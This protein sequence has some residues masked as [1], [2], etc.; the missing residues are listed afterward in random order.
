VS[1]YIAQ[2]EA[3][4]LKEARKKIGCCDIAAKGCSLC[5]NTWEQ[6]GKIWIAGGNTPMRFVARSGKDKTG[7]VVMNARVDCLVKAANDGSAVATAQG[8]VAD[9]W[10]Y[11]GT[12]HGM[13][14]KLC[15]RQ[16]YPRLCPNTAVTQ[17]QSG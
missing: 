14:R 10:V 4:F 16:G 15:I 9:L 11:K 8:V 3:Q 2:A 1:V 12:S 7:I 13:C 6:E 5:G 17:G